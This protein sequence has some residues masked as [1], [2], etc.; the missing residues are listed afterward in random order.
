MTR[1]ARQWAVARVAILAT[2]IGLASCD[3]GGDNGGVPN[4]FDR[5][6]MLENFGA[7]LILPAYVALQARV[8]AL[9]EAADQ[10]VAD[11][12]TAS[13]GILRDRLKD[14][15]MAWQNANLFQFGPA[16]AA[17]MRPA[18]NTFPANVNQIEAN[19]A[20]GDYVLGS[21]A[22]RAAAGFPTLDYLLHGVGTTAEEIVGKYTT[23][24]SATGRITYLAD[25]VAFIKSTT[26]QVV[27]AWDQSGG[28][29]LAEF[30]S[31]ARGGTDVGSSLGE[32]INALILHYERFVRD[33]KIGIP[34]G[35][36]SA[37]VP[38]PTATEAFYS[39]Y[40]LELAVANVVAIRRL[41][42]GTGLNGASGIG[43]DDNLRAL[44]AADL[45][46]EI[47]AALGEAI[48]GL[49]SLDDPLSMQIE[50]DVEAVTAVF[51]SMQRAVV[52]LKADM[53]SVLGVTVTFQDNDGD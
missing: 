42:R 4:G 8:D 19:V 26:D 1:Q 37:G 32:L 22:N 5:R 27:D 38:R 47:D 24:A 45:A 23:D 34:A 3:S 52:L 13:L 29:F 50:T 20:S 41:F 49:Q 53:T 44:D 9:S 48:A 30:L 14:A 40:S 6:A 28:N 25:N 46:N 12:N 43:L 2:A 51:V 35:V 18:L 10:F 36:R 21:L 33:G 39:G 15:W 11:P 17:V 31:A 16:E 7:N